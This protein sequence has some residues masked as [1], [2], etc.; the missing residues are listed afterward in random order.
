MPKWPVPPQFSLKNGQ[1][2]QNARWI[3]RSDGSLMIICDQM[4][5]GVFNDQM[6]QMKVENE[7]QISTLSN[8]SNIDSSSLT[9]INH[10][11]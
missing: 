3:L 6:D 10:E 7:H 4:D 2:F 8:K 11:V 5:L 1:S 9:I